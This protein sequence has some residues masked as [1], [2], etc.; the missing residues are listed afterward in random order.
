[1]KL[2]KQIRVVAVVLGIL[3]LLMAWVNQW[4]ISGFMAMLALQFAMLAWHHQK[5]GK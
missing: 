5:G 2:V 3:A 4:F 1:M